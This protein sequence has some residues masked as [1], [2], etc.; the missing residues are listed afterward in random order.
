MIKPG[1]IQITIIDG[2]FCS[3]L[4][5]IDAFNLRGLELSGRKFTWANSLDNLSYEKLDRVLASM[6]WESMFPHSTVL[7]LTREISDHTPLFLNTGDSSTLGNTPMF[8]FELRWLLRDGFFDIVKDIW[9][10]TVRGQ[11]SLERWQFKIRR[12][13]QHLR[14]W[15]KNVSGTYKKEKKQLLDKLSDLDKKAETILLTS[16]ELN[17][18]HSL[19]ERLAQ[20]LREEEIKWYQRAKVK[21]L[22][23]GDANTKYFHLVANGKH[24][25]TRIFQL[26]QEEGLICGMLN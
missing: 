5:V 18:K 13:R 17:L 20:L 6:E 24:R 4:Y 11:T 21:N 3:M 9:E 26:E 14:G 10:N 22:L 25:K 16:D 2:R 1:E 23:E 19:L 12:L 8:K 15:A 7:A